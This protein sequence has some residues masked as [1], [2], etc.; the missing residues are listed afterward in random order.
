M[1]DIGHVA[2]ILDN[3]PEKDIR[4]ICL[5]DGERILGLGDQGANGMGIATGKLALYTA[6]AGVP[7]QMCLPVTRDCGTNNGEHLAEPFYIDLCQERVRGDKFE[8]LAEGFM[9]TAK[10]KYEDKALLQFED[11]GNSTAFPLL[12]KY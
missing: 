1:Y 11:F 9:K 12:Q 3:W 8:R 10:A 4:A 6:C 2:E 5:T 7:P